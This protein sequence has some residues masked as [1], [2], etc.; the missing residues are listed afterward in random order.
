MKVYLFCQRL[1]LGVYLKDFFPILDVRQ[2]NN[3]LTIESA[4][5]KQSRVEHVGTVG[6]GNDNYIRVGFKAVHFYQNLV[7]RLLAFI[8]S[9]TQAR[10]ALATDRVYFINEDNARRILLGLLKQIAHARGA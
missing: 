5:T 10:T 3:Y 7:E 4:R 1:V 9:S 2:I 6:C 8:V